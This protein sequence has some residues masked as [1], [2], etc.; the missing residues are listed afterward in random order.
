MWDKTTSVLIIVICCRLA[1]KWMSDNKDR[2][3]TFVN[4][5]QIHPELVQNQIMDKLLSF[6]NTKKNQTNSNRLFSGSRQLKVSTM[7]NIPAI[8]ATPEVRSR[9]TRIT[10]ILV[11]GKQLFE[12]ENGMCSDLISGLSEYFVVHCRNH[13]DVLDIE[14]VVA[15]S[16]SCLF[17]VSESSF[18]NMNFMTIVHRARLS[19]K[20]L[21]F[22]KSI[23]LTIP[24]YEKHQRSLLLCSTRGRFSPLI[25]LPLPPISCTPNNIVTDSNCVPEYHTSFLIA[26]CKN[27]I[28][29]CHAST[30]QCIEQIC[31]Q[32]NINTLEQN[33]TIPANE[34]LDV[35]TGSLSINESSLGANRSSDISLKSDHSFSN[36]I[37]DQDTLGASLIVMEHMTNYNRGRSD[38]MFTGRS[39]ERDH[40]YLYTQKC[41]SKNFLELPNIA[42]CKTPPLSPIFKKRDTSNKMQRNHP[43]HGNGSINDVHPE[44][45]DSETPDSTTEETTYVLFPTNKN[46]FNTRIINW[47]RDAKYIPN[48]DCMS[49]D[50]GSFEFQDVDFTASLWASNSDDD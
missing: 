45:V 7:E 41:T 46:Q 36:N 43:Q 15:N 4:I 13:G 38:F 50:S 44:R 6:L 48:E 21:I 47:P 49:E 17:L 1:L 19:K 28:K 39:S 16:D 3:D 40:Q 35:E 12:E 8:T 33:A 29:Y 31:S 37:I 26:S 10:R 32:L 23:N 24:T 30:S 27:A 14:N 25:S 9:D 20:P 5:L 18:D 34:K 22:L 11:V 2:I 42:T